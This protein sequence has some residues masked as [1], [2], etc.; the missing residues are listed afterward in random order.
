MPYIV[1]IREP[2]FRCKCGQCYPEDSDTNED[3]LDDAVRTILLHE[4]LDYLSFEIDYKGL[5]LSLGDNAKLEEMS[6]KLK[7][8]FEICKLIKK[9]KQDENDRFAK[10]EKFDKLKQ[11]FEADEWEQRRQNEEKE[12]RHQEYLKLKSEIG[13]KK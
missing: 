11:E 10:E 6:E 2:D 7:H 5:P 8:Y 4:N 13:D 12:R 1:R 3:T 9:T